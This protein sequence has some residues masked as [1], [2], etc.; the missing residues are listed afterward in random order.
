MR[1]RHVF[2]VVPPTLL[3]GFK[4]FSQY[5][6]PGYVKCLWATFMAFTLDCL[7]FSIWYVSEI[8]DENKSS[9]FSQPSS[10][11]L[12][13]PQKYNFHAVLLSFS[14]K[15]W[16]YWRIALVPLSIGVTGV[17]F[18]L[19]KRDT[20]QQCHVFLR[21]ADEDF[22][23]IGGSHFCRYS[24]WPFPR[25]TLHEREAQLKMAGFYRSSMWTL[26]TKYDNSS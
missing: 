18:H 14:V 5:R 8:L 25:S 17:G 19:A 1:M 13:R 12:C 3:P 22:S 16:G 9:E 4:S 15:T 7:D 23:L 26:D 24:R 10:L 20:I 2:W 21:G 11:T 6:E